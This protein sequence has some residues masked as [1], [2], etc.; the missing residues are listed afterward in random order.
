MKITRRELKH[1][2][3]EMLG[4][5]EVKRAGTVSG[6]T[7][8]AKL[9]ALLGSFQGSKLLAIAMGGTGG[10]AA[11]AAS[12]GTYGRGVQ[13]EIGGAEGT[14]STLLK[15]TLLQKGSESAFKVAKTAASFAG[16]LLL[17]AAVWGAFNFLPNMLQKSIEQLDTVEGVLKK[18]RALRRTGGK[19]TPLKLTDI[20][21][22]PGKT[23]VVKSWSRYEM[24]D[25][26]AA[27][28]DT[29]E[30]K[31]LYLELISEEYTDLN[32]KKRK[33][34]LIDKDFTTAILKRRK[35]IKTE[36]A[37]KMKNQLIANVKK[38]ALSEEEAK[39][40]KDALSSQV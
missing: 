15:K 35:T 20:A 40:L 10:A 19:D 23:L 28:M 17:V 29:Q 26:L 24:V 14:A 27:V 33:G 13:A 6:A 8:T 34:P 11:G 25:Y 37:E 21:R 9:L 1:L 31:R 30:G 7:E 39:K 16:P 3:V 2:V 12:G 22:N 18:L 4:E 5:A 38:G 36:A 32:G